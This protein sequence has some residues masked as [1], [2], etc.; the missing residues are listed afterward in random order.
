MES[1][2]DERNSF[3]LVCDAEEGLWSTAYKVTSIV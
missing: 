2:C 1:S 3:V